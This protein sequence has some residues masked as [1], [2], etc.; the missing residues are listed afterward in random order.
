M[1]LGAQVGGYRHVCFPTDLRK[2]VLK[3]NN[4]PE[5]LTFPEKIE[6]TLF[7]ARIGAFFIE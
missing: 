3:H 4:R 5:N 1:C 6:F 2:E 7:E